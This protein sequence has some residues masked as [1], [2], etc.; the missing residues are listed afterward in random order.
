[1]PQY[2]INIGALPNDGTGDPL[3]T[4]FNE[5]NLNFDQVFAAG[6]VLS[7]VRIANNTILTT[8]TNGN[9]VL[10]PNGIG[11]VQANVNIVPNTS[12]IRNL[13]SADRRWSTLYTQYANISGGLTLANLT[14]TGDILVSGNL[15]VTGNIINV[16][17]IVTDA[18]TIQL[19]NTAGTANVANG[20]GITV[21]AND[22][23]AT[24]LF[25]S[26]NNIWSTNIGIGVSGPI[27]GTSLAVS[28]ATVYGNVDAI[29]GNYTG[30]IVVDTVSV[31]TI[32]LNPN[33]GPNVNVLPNI[34]VVD[35]T[36]FEGNVDIDGTL[37]VMGNVSA[38]YFIGD[39]SLLTGLPTPYANANAV[40]YG[41]TGWTGNIIPAG[42]GVYSLGNA[43]NYWSNI[44]VSSNTI[45]IG[46]VPVGITGNV[47]TVDGQPVLSNDSD[48][49]ITTTG[50][51][52]AN[53]FIGDGSLLTGTPSGATGPTG[54]TGPQGA[55]GIAGVDGA[56]G[57][58]GPS[59]T[60]GATGATGPQGIQGDIG[61]T[62]ATG[63]AGTD[64]ATGATGSFSGNLTANINGQGYSISNVATI[65]A[66][67]NITGGNLISS[68][69]IFG[70]PDLILGNTANAAA[71]KT[72]I[73]T[74]GAN[75]YIQTGNGTVSSTGNIVFAPYLDA[76]EK[77]V[78]NTLSGNV[79]A[80]NFIGNISITGNVT[81]TSANV[82]L[83]AGVNTWTFNNV[84]N[85]VLPGNTFAVNY[86]N[87]TAV[88][89]VTRFA[90]SWSVTTGTANYSFT[91]DGGHTYTMWVTG[92]IPN[93]IIVWNATA[94]VTN[95]NVPV[96]GTQYAWYYPTGNALVLN[97]IPGQIIGTAGV[98]ANAEPVVANTNVFTFSI[99]NNSGSTQVVNY[100]WVRVS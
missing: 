95:T 68:A 55:T 60:D 92:N 65:T 67:G 43:T 93:G 82:Q 51:I 3:R 48:S 62:G 52:S 100:G 66:T 32:K 21:G 69:T 11:V 5:V 37:F 87:G 6:P 73:A 74:F 35:D 71:T 1:M 79:T 78:I 86:A 61:A 30:N 81:G 49:S 10:A 50:N 83:V 4:A 42:N 94:T 97:S 63:V 20:S 13:G 72:R 17:N 25:N 41:Q 70:N 89:P 88:N 47:L 33:A 34:T 46:G 56:T 44:W 90:G 57:A 9:L 99:T 53:Y 45:Y 91:V 18:K 14:A 39:G 24:F 96:I 80:Q 98:I 85:L 54:A 26:A 64:G 77:V 15:T 16:A 59:G 29:N 76:T 12:N 84:G 22:S 23:I 40:A 36:V 27:T 58:T 8:N 2:T 75:S 31:R 28:D 38:D 7:N 19:A